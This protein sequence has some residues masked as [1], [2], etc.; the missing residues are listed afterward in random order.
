MKPFVNPKDF[1][2]HAD[3]AHKVE[4]VLTDENIDNSFRYVKKMMSLEE[5]AELRG[6]MSESDWIPVGVNGMKGDYQE[7]DPIGSW[8]LSSFQEEYSKVLFERVADYIDLDK[9]CGETTNTDWD[10][11]TSWSAIG[12]NPLLRFIKYTDGGYLVP[13]YDAPYVADEFE[14]T[15]ASVVIYLDGNTDDNGNVVG[16]DGE[17]RFLKDSQYGTPVGERDLEDKAEP[18]SD[19]DVIRSISP[20][21]GDAIIFDHRILHESHAFRALVEGAEKNILRTD[22]MYRRKL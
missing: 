22:I 10:G 20:E 7:G 1:E 9:E 12:I 3:I 19:E 4:A 13:H 8:R 16:K 14:R 15:L 6:H 18:A 5:V 11:T 21:A 2:L 17:T